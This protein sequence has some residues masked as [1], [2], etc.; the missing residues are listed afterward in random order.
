MGEEGEAEDGGDDD[1]D[2][3]AGAGGFVCELTNI[4][5]VGSRWRNSSRV[6]AITLNELGWISHEESVTFDAGGVEGDDDDAELDGL[7][8]SAK[9][10]AFSAAMTA[11]TCCWRDG[12]IGGE[13]I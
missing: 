10:A 8:W 9:P 4:R 5:C 11:L 6:D 7:K 12:K 3:D 13:T 1:E 2:G